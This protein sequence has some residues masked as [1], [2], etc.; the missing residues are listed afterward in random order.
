VEIPEKLKILLVEDDPGHIALVRRS[1]KPPAMEIELTI[2]ESLAAARRLL[3]EKNFDLIITD[4]RLSD[5]SGIELLPSDAEDAA[6]PVVIMTSQGNEQEAVAALKAGAQD[7]LVK[8]PTLF[9]NLPRV[10]VRTV[11][12]WQNLVR[13]RQA[14]AALRKSEAEY[15]RLSRQFEVVLHGIPDQLC[16]VS[17]DLEIIWSNHEE[18]KTTDTSEIE[19][20]RFRCYQ[21]WH[22]RQEPCPK[23]P[24]LRVFKS[25]RNDDEIIEGTRGRIWGVKAFPLKDEEGRVTQ[26]ISLASDITEKIRLRAEALRASQLA[27][28]GVLAAGVAH[29]INN[30]INGIINY[31]QLLADASDNDENREIA[32][33][34]MEEGQ[35]IAGIVRSLLTFT[36]KNPEEKNRV[37]L[38]R[39]VDD[40]LALSRS[41]LERDQIDLQIDIPANLPPVLGHHQQLQQVLLNLIANAR[42][43]LNKK[44]PATSAGKKLVINAMEISQ[45]QRPL[46]RLEVTDY[47]TG[48]SPQ[49]LDRIMDPFYTTKAPDQGTGLGLSISH[50]IIK[51]HG[52]AIFCTSIEGEKTRFTIHLPTATEAGKED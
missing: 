29:E 13:R 8:N 26:V 49:H 30:P 10:V 43:A 37:F 21:R 6:W 1:F 17:P 38:N 2:G 42:F 20:G 40:T 51:D 36:R 7:Y 5:G 16:L 45:D 47:G 28:L 25:G 32:G 34:I 46:I 19:A 11:D 27:S 22:Q 31:A 52:G 14:E 39:V 12:G 35:R 33:G 48:I 50:N 41:Q 9:D 23:C 15:R 18:G 3:A 4:L 44:F 24:V